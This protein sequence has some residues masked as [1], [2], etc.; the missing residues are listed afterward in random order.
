LYDKPFRGDKNTPWDSPS[1]GSLGATTRQG[2]KQG[3]YCSPL[4]IS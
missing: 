1:L 2:P 3:P 4:K